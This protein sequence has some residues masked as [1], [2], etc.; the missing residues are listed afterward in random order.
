MS[1]NKLEKSN[2][3]EF[4]FRKAFYDKNNYIKC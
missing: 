4:D 3:Q 2:T 1:Y